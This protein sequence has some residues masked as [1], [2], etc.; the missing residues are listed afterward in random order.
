[1]FGTDRV[2]VLDRVDAGGDGDPGAGVRARVRGDLDAVRVRFRGDGLD[3]LLRPIRRRVDVAVRSR[4]QAS[5]V[6]VDLDPVR[7]VGELL[8][9]GLA[10]Y[11]GAVADH[12][13][14]RELPV[15]AI[16]LDRV[17]AGRGERGAHDF[18]A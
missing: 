12:D 6:G 18:E 11:V 10:T 8:A 9:Y 5:G 15:R 7:A 13:A 2:A 1:G 16:V 4:P 17:G 14:A 3:L